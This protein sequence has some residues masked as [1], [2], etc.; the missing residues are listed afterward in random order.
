MPQTP[1]SEG[2]GSVSG[3]SGSTKFDEVLRSDYPLGPLAYAPFLGDDGILIP[4]LGN[5]RVMS[6]EK[7][8]V[9]GEKPTLKNVYS[10]SGSPSAVAVNTKTM[11]LCDS[12][13]K[14]IVVADL[15]D[16]EGVSPPPPRTLV[17]HYD[18]RI[19]KGPNSVC[20][21]QRGVIYFTD[22][23]S[24]G[25]SDLIN[26][27]GSVFMFDPNEEGVDGQPG[28]LRPLALNCLAYPCGICLSQ[29]ESQ[30]FVCEG[31]NNRLLRFVQHPRGVFHC[32]VFHQFSGGFGPRAIACHPANGD[33]YVARFEFNDVSRSY[34]SVCVL[35]NAPNTGIRAEFRLPVQ[36]LYG[37]AFG[38]VLRR[39]LFV[40]ARDGAQSVVWSSPM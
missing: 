21:D 25:E 11:Y 15:P 12:Y 35:P 31:A 27:T 28:V 34:G 29:D 6:V 1:L 5:G 2:F 33:L 39:T 17:S 22:G 23:G 20:I 24:F 37:V 13:A 8:A 14:S 40:T 38:G 32:S 10:S 3:M 30:V 19:L 26:K 16:E 7:A 4:G 36:E 9:P 18:G